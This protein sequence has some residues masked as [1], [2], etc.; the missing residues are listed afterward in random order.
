MRSR[1]WCRLRSS[2]G[3]GPSGLLA[4]LLAIVLQF[5]PRPAE[6][7]FAAQLAKVVIR[8]RSRQQLQSCPY[9]LGD[10]AAAGLLGLFKKVLWDF[11]RDFPRRHSD[12]ILPYFIP[13]S[14]TVFS[15]KVDL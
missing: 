1:C 4:I 10:A 3:G 14:N 8:P 11:D 5:F 13:V 9:G 12:L 15:L 7:D 6:A 2:R